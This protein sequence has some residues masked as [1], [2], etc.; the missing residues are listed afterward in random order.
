MDNLNGLSFGTTSLLQKIP[1]LAY[2]SPAS[3]CSL[4]VVLLLSI[5]EKDGDQ[6]PPEAHTWIY[7]QTLAKLH[8]ALRDCEGVKTAGSLA[9]SMCLFLCEAGVIFDSYFKCGYVSDGYTEFWLDYELEKSGGRHRI[10]CQK[11]G[12]I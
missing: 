4:L 8:I 9:A 1:I 5:A 11:A 12:C 6:Y 7:S 2:H 3:D 10:S